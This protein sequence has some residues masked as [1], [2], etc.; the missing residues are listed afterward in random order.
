MRR[1]EFIALV[2]GC[3]V[4]WPLA[5]RAQDAGPPVIGLLQSG[6]PSAYD[7]SGFHQGLKETGFIEGLNLKIEYRWAN[8]DPD[9]LPELA[10]DLVNR[11]VR[12][13]AAVASI[14]AARAAA[15]ATNTIPIVFGVGGDPVALGLVGSINR[16]GGN[17]TGLTSMSGELIGKQLAILHDLL[18][19]ATRF[20]VLSNPQGW[21]HDSIVKTRKPPPQRSV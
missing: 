13:I 3:A 21:I 5:A 6:T 8:E 12:V 11:Q 18:P 19:Q 15:T 14:E 17:V 4:A 2:G 7:L 16:P 20:G 1:R 9:R 10:A